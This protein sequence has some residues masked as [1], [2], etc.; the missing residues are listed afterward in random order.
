MSAKL[1][2]Q[3]SKY[4]DGRLNTIS[5][6]AAGKSISLQFR[7]NELRQL[8]GVDFKGAATV[9]P[10]IADIV[11]IFTVKQDLKAQTQG[12]GL[13]NLYAFKGLAVVAAGIEQQQPLISNGDLTYKSGFLYEVLELMCYAPAGTLPDAAPAIFRQLSV[14]GLGGLTALPYSLTLSTLLDYVYELDTSSKRY[15]L[16]RHDSEKWN[17][18]L[19]LQA[20][21]A[22]DT[23]F[24]WF[25]LIG[26]YSL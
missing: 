2:T 17:W 7:Y 6:K 21:A 8:A 25:G 14:S 4:D 18:Y 12:F 22:A 15:F 9:M 23:T 3:A 5:I 10:S 11:S 26:E 19:D 20:N 16:L 24:S 13:V 1:V